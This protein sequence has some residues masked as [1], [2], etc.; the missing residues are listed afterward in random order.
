MKNVEQFEGIAI[1]GMAGR[2]P[3]AS[4]VAGF[5]Q[6]LRQGVEAISF[7]SDEDLLAAGVTPSLLGRPDYVRACGVLEG[8][9]LF[10]A[11]LFGVN[12]REAELLDPQ[13]RVFLECAWQALE[14]AAYDPERYGEAVGVYAGVSMNSY[15]LNNLSRN[16]E[17]IERVGEFQTMLGSDKDFLPTRVSYKL[18]LRGP[19]FNVQT[20]C[21]TSL[22]AVHVACQALLNGE[23][24]MALAGGV[25]ISVPQQSGYIYQEGGINS[26]DGHCRAFDAE[27][28][29][30]VRGNGVGIVVLKR[31][32]EALT[33]GDRIY[34]VIRGT[35]TN[36]DGSDKIG[37]TAPSINGQAEVIAQGLAIAGVEPETVTY[38]ETHGTGTEL[39]DPVEVAALTQVFGSQRGRRNFCAI[40]SVKTNVGHLDA[41]A[42]IAGLIK[43]ALSLHH[44]ELPPS[45]HF[46]RPNP[47]I[48]FESGPFFVNTELRDWEPG[49]GPRRAGVSS[50][51]IGGT[52]AHAV[53]EE[54]PPSAVGSEPARD[55]QLL[56]LSARTPAAL[57]R[58]TEGLAQ[59][60]VENPEQQL[61]D[62]AHTLQVGRR[63][64]EHRR[65]VLCRNAGEAAA[66]LRAHDSRVVTGA[67]GL[68]DR[69]AVLMF[70]GQG[71]QYPWM[72]RELYEREKVYRREFDACDGVL[73]PLLGLSLSGLLYGEA[74][75][76]G[77]AEMLRQTWVTQPALFCVEYAVA[78]QL[79][80]WG[81]KAEAMIGHSV[82]ELVAACL[83][84][85]F[86]VE[87][88]LRLV[89][90]R[91]RLMQSMEPGQML[92]VGLSEG[93]VTGRLGEGLWLAAVNG[94]RLCAVSGRAE[95]VERL[96]RELAAE[97]VSAR[98]LQTSHA[99]HSAMMEE[100]AREFVNEVGRVQLREPRVR[101]I[102]NVSGTWVTKEEATSPDY[103]GRQ[104]R[105]PV[106]FWPGLLETLKGGGKLFVEAGPGRGLSG[107]AREASRGVKGSAVARA[108]RG[109]DEKG[110]AQEWLQ[111]CVAQVWANGGAVNWKAMREGERRLRVQAPGYAFERERFWVEPTEPAS[112]SEESNRLLK[113]S[114]VAEWFYVPSWKRSR[115]SDL[116]GRSEPADGG[117][118]WLVFADECGVGAELSALLREQGRRV[119]T[120]TPSHHFSRRSEAAFTVNPLMPEHYRQLL[121]LLREEEQAPGKILHL[122]GVTPE[123]T[124]PP[125]PEEYQQQFERAQAHGLHSLLY[126]TQALNAD[127][128]QHGVEIEVVTTQA[129][130]VTG[131]EQIRAEKATVL[132]ACKVIPQEHPRISCRAVDV[133]LTAGDAP[134]VARQLMSEV[135]AQGGGRV[136]AYRGRHR[137]E[138]G[139]EPVRVEARREARRL[140]KGGVYLITGGTGGVGLAL[141]EYLAREAAAKLVLVSR[142]G[143]EAE[144]RAKAVSRLVAAGAE[145][146]ALKAD[147]SDE[148]A[149]RGALDETLRRFGRLDGVVHAAGLAGLGAI[150]AI[151]DAGPEDFEA[152]FLPKVRGL[153]TL[154]K[155]LEGRELDF[156][157]LT[158]SLSSVLGGLGFYAYASANLFLDAYAHQAARASSISWTSVNLDGW[159]FGPQEG[160]AAVG[161]AVAELAMFP[162]EGAEVFGRIL[163]LEPSPQLIVSTGNLELRLAH[164]VGGGPAADEAGPK[165]QA[166]AALHARPDL[167]SAYAAPRNEFE[168]A[169]A[170]VWQELLGIE[171]VGVNDDFF[172]L[173]GHSLLATQVASRIKSTF[174][175]DLPLRVLFESPTAADLAR[176]VQL[177]LP[178]EPAR[179]VPPV[180]PADRSGPLPL[181]YAQQRLWFI[182]Q[183]EP[184][185]PLY[186]IP[187]ALRLTGRLDV[188]AAESSLNEIIRRHEV[189]RTSFATA[190]GEPVQ[191]IG[192]YPPLTLE[193]VD[194]SGEDEAE[195][196]DSRVEQHARRE[197]QQP[198]DLGAGPMLRA[199]LLRLADEEHVL[200]LTIHHIAS[201]GWSTSILVREFSALYEAFLQGRPADLPELLLQYADF[202]V[203][204]N[205]WLRGEVLEG[206]LAYWRGQLD[207]LTTL[208]LP[209]D[210][211]RPAV[212][213][214][215]GET[216]NFRLDEELSHKLKEL[217]RRHNVTL[218]MSL[219]AAFQALLFRYTGQ[220]DIAVGTDIANRNRLET[221]QLVG[222]F[223]NE[224][225]LRADLSAD[226]TFAELLRQVRRTT[227]DAYI[228]QDLPFEKLVAELQPER[229]LSR[230]PLFQVKLVLQ[231]TASGDLR[232]PDLQVTL[233]EEKQHQV[234]KFDLAFVFEE[235]GPGLKG[236]LEFA[237]DLFSRAT[238]ER[239]LS[240]F[241]TLLRAVADDPTR[242][243]RS[244]PLLTA[245]ER[246]RL[247]FDFNDTARDYPRSSCVHQ[248][249]RARA[250]ASPEAIS[251][252]CEGQTL[253]YRQLEERANRLA[254][255]LLSLGVG[256]EFRVAV[257]M[258]RSADMVVA[259]LGILKAGAAYVP[260]DPEYP[261]ERTAWLLRNSQCPVLLTQESLQDALPTQWIHVL[262]VDSKW[263]EVSS[264]PA[265]D[266][267]TPV[268]ADNLAYVMYTSG[269]TG[270]PKGVEVAHRSIVR[271]LMSADY[272][273]F[274]ES[275]AFLQISPVSFDASTLELWAP[276]L[277]G[278]RCVLYPER[279]PVPDR[280]AAFIEVNQVNSAWLTSSLFNAVMDEMPLALA[281]LRQLLVG[282]EALS[283]SHV[284]KAAQL[285]VSTRL[286]NGYGPTEGTT[287]T[288][289]YP[290]PAGFDA[291]AGAR[292]VPLGP[293]ISNTRVYILDSEYEPVPVGVAGELFIG[294]DGLARDYL[295]R[296]GLTAERFVPD[297]FGGAAGARLYRSGD[298]AR[299]SQDGT[300]EYLG[301]ID[302]QVKLRGFR[303]EPGEIEAHLRETPGI[304]DAA[305]VV[306]E[307]EPGQKRLVAYVVPAAEGWDKADWLRA[308]LQ[309]KLPEYMVPSQLV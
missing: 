156:A 248:L 155:V 139:F 115:P 295:N 185:S 299:W 194:L 48:D 107:L 203:W 166:Q 287:F 265:T 201:D 154:E 25:S 126:L 302:Q 111:R 207:S 163:S 32:S 280:L 202:A 305:V 229:D 191:V 215:K 136:V 264:F 290:V 246:E 257:C 108:M 141:A 138:Q 114:D 301:R 274:D 80:A 160:P 237:T 285:L 91:G 47:R 84:G 43:T 153:L 134:R 23:C 83:A 271:L 300:V 63:V 79:M 37:Y 211:P 86:T 53:L 175:V 232:L 210:F 74:G 29:G 181:S 16:R 178:E 50:F 147:V 224:L 38:I 56:V 133:E 104:L 239:L 7:F 117:R 130:E 304:R 282:G 228:H 66:S 121:S 159:N 127:G 184:G 40:G 10:D 112:S 188:A 292:G 110:D 176:Q 45:L 49:G 145:V 20:A 12:P 245:G 220:T 128:D 19:S 284:S 105:Q 68:R 195:P 218:F 157:L 97:G 24:D 256:A 258:E 241:Q 171:R 187:L 5:W 189:L 254:H 226:L 286:I 230:A 266:P 165:S 26:P 275:L 81:L 289:C 90:A 167:D 137:W 150:N 236:S 118:P 214:H 208:E 174:D 251:V 272:A 235:S 78:R 196:A 281:P 199:K 100:A 61:A 212:A 273:Q 82:G 152:H 252:V 13:Q 77:A 52:N 297:P 262:C 219:M 164:W 135:S 94:K 28:K 217:S 308:R 259:L 60:L 129:Q 168:A 42:G 296:P 98:R 102:S 183:L 70:P 34:A 240:H 142:G 179:Q 51:G 41:A 58:M 75:E 234:A 72:G 122:W 116:L 131:A 30:T 96:E 249:F 148:A 64:L 267:E 106:R 253:T 39:G 62:L 206:Q 198:F 101:F 76:A 55:W 200:L 4:D 92:S 151:Q 279:I 67:S 263:D 225:V 2:F 46:S 124:A 59:H 293:P 216:I 9:E 294:G 261:V 22:V 69:E 177:A 95:E 193:V 119:F 306:R 169:V 222:F 99:F 21:S 88:A 8:A 31:L 35:A 36:N 227:L 268:R 231:N 276:L 103:W 242:R 18:N 182:D 73:R 71:A 120:V 197:A 14:D 146:L 309:Q 278:G 233:I 3:G 190:D 57:E 209:T 204:Q 1:I 192:D 6:N 303:I 65:A 158:S 277:H 161:Q 221:E 54:A 15:F 172:E 123:Q 186:N 89:A 17:L 44:R 149:M 247:L 269:S 85:V 223:V 180:V 291:Q 243:V 298:L 93:E 238:A 255:Y 173:G 307:D 270:T 288:C 213:S 33:D 27:A 140:K 244:L 143:A 11:G 87:E 283:V 113:R 170:G 205:N 144:G 260:I 132:G 125:A 250:E 162:S 109:A